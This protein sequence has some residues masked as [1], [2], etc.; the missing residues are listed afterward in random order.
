MVQTA[1]DPWQ[2]RLLRNAEAPV[3]TFGNGTA[4]DWGLET[5]PDL[6]VIPVT[7]AA[8]KS[9]GVLLGF[10]I[11]LARR[12]M[13]LDSWQVPAGSE[14]SFDELARTLLWSLGGRFLWIA[15]L[16]NGLRAYPDC[17]AQVPCV[18][19]PVARTAGSTAFALLDVTEYEARRDI[20][21]FNRLGVDGEG[22]HIGVQRLLPNHYLDLTSFTAHRFWPVGG[23]GKDPDPEDIVTEIIDVVQAQIE[24]LTGVTKKLGMALTAGHE[25]RMLLACA[26]PY[27][28]KVDMVT[29][30]GGDRHETDSVLARR[31][32][33]DQGLSHITLAR[34]TATVEQRERFILRGGHCNADS[35][36]LYHPS[37]W[38]IAKS[39]NLLG[40]LGGEVARAFFWKKDDN[41]DSIISSSLLMRRFGLPNAQPLK[42]AL[43][44][45]L[46]DLPSMNGLEILDLAYIE[47]RNGP[48]YAA[49]FCCDPTLVRFAP[50]FTVRTVEL[51]LRLPS[52]W[53]RENRLGHAI[54]ERLWPELGRYPYNSLGPIKDTFIK[55]QRLVANP[56]LIAKKLRRIG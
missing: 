33:T 24:A 52:K 8:G 19:D 31:I 1:L 53:K 38:P 42:H 49:Q 6:P 54:I 50:L 5:G 34:Q 35:N 32:A 47:H 15:E 17:S 40:G 13:I 23:S 22:W 29:V 12:A 11:D 21:L 37:V 51:M 16:P 28:D 7:D 3:H 9:V 46:S 4:D 56:R 26:R 30:V 36:S 48:W 45:W 27:L 20:S 18:F 39:H 41:E 25:T 14:V 55:L 44:N 2:Y 10:P 43:D